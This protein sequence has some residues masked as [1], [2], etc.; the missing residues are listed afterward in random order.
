[1]HEDK[2]PPCSVSNILDNW[3]RTVTRI[4]F[5]CTAIQAES[6]ELFDVII[7][8]V[9][10]N[11][12]RKFQRHCLSRFSRD[13]SC[14]GCGMDRDICWSLAVRLCMGG[15]TVLGAGTLPISFFSYSVKIMRFYDFARGPCLL[16]RNGRPSQLRFDLHIPGMFAVT[17][18]ASYRRPHQINDQQMSRSIPQPLQLTSRE[19]RRKQ[20]L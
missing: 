8:R 1:M 19:K 7:K 18:A 3:L 14:R 5:S 16:W 10:V 6:N 15:L 13:V 9:F 2:V 20:C 17:A 12:F 11:I 4:S